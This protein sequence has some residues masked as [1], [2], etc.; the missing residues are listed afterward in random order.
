[1]PR[2]QLSS[3][4]IILLAGVTMIALLLA[5]TSTS[6]SAITRQRPS[7]QQ[8]T[9]CPNDDSDAQ[10]ECEDERA[11]M[12]EEA[13]QRTPTDD[14]GYPY[15]GPSTATATGTSTGAT[16]TATATAT[17]TQVATTDTNRTGADATPTLADGSSAEAAT[18][19]PG[20]AQGAPTPTVIADLICAPGIP[21]TVTGTA[22]AYAPLLL[23]F[24]Q[25]PVGGGSASSSGTFALK[26]V[27]GKERSG[28]YQVTVRVRGTSQLVRTLSC[29]VP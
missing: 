7:A 11:M 26:L 27:V 18:G 17:V 16:S 3:P 8:F 24:D 2:Q 28:L 15:N 5:G 25:R 20:V 13:A 4:L 10:F 22:P 19:V 14:T 9:P 12:T 6:T 29:A 1:M 23:F 21:T